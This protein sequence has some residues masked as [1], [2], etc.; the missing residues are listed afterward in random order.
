[1]ILG[2]EL[3]CV[4]VVVINVVV[5]IWVN[6]VKFALALLPEESVTTIL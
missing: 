3:I 4:G 5:V 1:M 2:V 6:T